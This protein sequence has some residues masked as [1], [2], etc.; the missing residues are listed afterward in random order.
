M[1]LKSIQIKKFRSIQ[2]S[3]EFTID[4]VST[5]LVGKNE[6]GKT[7]ILNAIEKINSLDPERSKFTDLEYPRAEMTDFRNRE[8]ED[9]INAVFST[10]EL[11][12]AEL[13]GLTAILG[14]GVLKLNIIRVNRGY[15]DSTVWNFDI[16]EKKCLANIIE[17]SS[18][19]DEEKLELN[20][21]LNLKILWTHLTTKASQAG[22]ED[23]INER[24][25]KLLDKIERHFKGT[26]NDKAIR[27]SA[28]QAA[29][30]FLSPRLPKMVY[31]GS[32]L[33]MP[34]QISLNDIKT[35][36]G[37]KEEDSNKVFLALLDLINKS[38]EDLEDIKSFE[39]LQ[40]ELEG[41]SNKLTREIFRYWSQNRHLKVQFRFEQGHPGDPSPFNTGYVMRTRIENQ[42]YGVTTNFDDRSTGFVWFFSFLIWFS[43]VKKNYGKNL[44]LLL[45]EPGLSLH[46]KAQSDLLRYFEERLSD[47]QLIYTTHSPF[48]VDTKN[49][50]RVRTVED[51]FIESDAPFGDEEVSLGTE[52]GDRVLSADRDTLFPLQAALGYDITQSLFVGQ[53]TLLVEGPSEIL[54]LPWFSR[55]LKALGRTFLDP[56]WTLTPCG[57]IDKIPSFLSLFAGQE[58]NIATLVDFSDGDKKKVRNLRTSQLLS[59]GHV[60]SAD[61]YS[62]Q[63][64]ADIED[65]VGRRAYVDL[66]NKCYDLKGKEKIPAKKLKDSP[67]RAVKEVEQ[68][69]MTK[70]TSGDEFDH[71]RPSLFLTQ[72]GLNI[73]L[74]AI[75]VALDRF[76][77]LF[78]D[79]NALLD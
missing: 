57:G 40:G 24:E 67:V 43:Q 26:R 32:Y 23:V 28:W 49:I 61:T 39:L 2:D 21:K 19:H 4:P 18:L 48:M 30:S 56:R 46:A 27:V 76:E 70:A 11:E 77:K 34:G 53:H 74:A 41:A 72:Q 8:D 64:E 44:I 1:I 51:T 13:D 75:D 36:A 3:T 29:V 22:A 73:E 69:F 47:F 54:Y 37:A 50:L 58:L 10:W 55:K 9:D 7:S 63:S 62:G 60:M 65:L 25:Q 45:D 71:Y 5:C 14:E 6:S 31:F 68:H 78:E 59:A 79:L 52:V 12:E 33:K 15:H 42:K 17:S 16:D 66:V 20:Q 38:I 35:R